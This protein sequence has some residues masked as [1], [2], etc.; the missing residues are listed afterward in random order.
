MTRML[1]SLVIVGEILQVCCHHTLVVR[2]GDVLLHHLGLGVDADH[3]HPV[4]LAVDPVQVQ[5]LP[6]LDIALKS[7]IV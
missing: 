2:G 6:G 4:Q 7:Q 1:Y 3:E 5:G